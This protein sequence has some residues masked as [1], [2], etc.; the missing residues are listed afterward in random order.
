MATCSKVVT[1]SVIPDVT[2]MLT[3]ALSL[4]SPLHAIVIN[5][6]ATLKDRVTRVVPDDAIMTGFHHVWSK[7]YQ[8]K[9]SL[10]LILRAVECY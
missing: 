6:A 8:K 9:I 4:S 1:A 7:I 10:V 3:D 2:V 5:A